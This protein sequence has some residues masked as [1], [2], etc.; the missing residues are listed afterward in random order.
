MNSGSSGCVVCISIAIGSLQQTM[1]LEPGG[2]ETSITSEGHASARSR[3]PL[4]VPRAYRANIFHRKLPNSRNVTI[5][6]Q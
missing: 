1:R 2:S 3:P 6:A 5:Q 4:I